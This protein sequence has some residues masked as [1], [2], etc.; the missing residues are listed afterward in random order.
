MNITP[1]SDMPNDLDFG[2]ATPAR[3]V[4]D[5]AVPRYETAKHSGVYSNPCKKCGGS[6]VFRSFSGRVVGD[7][8]VCKGAGSQTFKTSPETREKARECAATRAER[9]ARESL[10]AFAQEC[11][12]MHAW[13][14][15]KAAGFGFAA[16]MLESVKQWGKLTDGQR[17]A[18]ERCMVRDAERDAERVAKAVERAAAPVVRL[19][20]LYTVLQRHS[21][22]YAGDLT[23]TR[24]REQSTVWVKHADADKAVGKIEAGVL[25]MWH[26]PGVDA[27]A[28]RQTLDEFEGAPLAAAVRFG[29]LTGRCCSCGRELT[30]PASIEAG[31][32]PICA[33][34]F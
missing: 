22:F 2:V 14:T 27:A 32:G 6:G 10:E 17:A 24:A 29:K 34:K 31:I 15:E 12:A 11:P 3:S 28:V 4:A 26:R 19:D 23:L 5:T 21:K 9:K 25:T 16:A 13:M 18:V 33:G 30:D 8:F 7:C 1:F 20:A